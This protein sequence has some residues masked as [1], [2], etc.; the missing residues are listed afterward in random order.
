MTAQP[1]PAYGLDERWV[2]PHLD[3]YAAYGVLFG[4]TWAVKDLIHEVADKVDAVRRKA[5]VINEVAPLHSG[6][7]DDG[8]QA[9]AERA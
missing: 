8:V 4:L 2:V 7:G 6:P 1:C 9:S 5:K 3:A